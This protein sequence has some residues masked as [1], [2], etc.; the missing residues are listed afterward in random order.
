V[1]FPPVTGPFG[2]GTGPIAGLY[3]PVSEADAAATLAAAWAGGVRQYDTAPQ[4]GAGLGERRLGAFLATRPRAEYV[5]STKVGR[6]VTPTGVSWDFSAD[7]VR[8]SLAESL[9]RTGLDRFDIVLIH[10]P[11]D[12]WAE[13]AG[14]AYPALRALRDE[15]VVGAIGVGMNQWRMPLRFVRETDIDVVLIAGRHT[16]LDR[17]ADPE[18]LPECHRR[19]VA[20]IAA[21]VL[22]SG[23]LADPRPGAPF[24]YA[25]APPEIVARAQALRDVCRSYGVPLAAAALQFPRR[26]PAVRSVLV[27]A[28]S[29]AEVTEDLTLAAHPIPDALWRDLDAAAGTGKLEPGGDAE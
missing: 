20:V 26:D 25:P 14:Q 16:V 13:A 29:P 5:V 17:T 12:H 23:I 22:N 9:D 21:G 24:N 6:L 7:G 10:D 15:G 27:G 18:L 28:R 11:D 8:R 4:Y 19:G 1:R 3:T 2:L